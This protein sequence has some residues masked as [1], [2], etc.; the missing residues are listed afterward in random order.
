MELHPQSKTKILL[1][2]GTPLVRAPKLC[3]VAD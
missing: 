3:L 2:K 1:F